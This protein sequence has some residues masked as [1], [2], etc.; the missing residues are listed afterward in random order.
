[1]DKS[2]FD[3]MKHVDKAVVE[4]EFEAALQNLALATCRYEGVRA[5]YLKFFKPKDADQSEVVESADTI[6]VKVSVDDE[7]FS[8]YVDSRAEKAAACAAAFSRNIIGKADLAM[9]TAWWSEYFRRQ[10]LLHPLDKYLD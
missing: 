8:A 2:N 9:R 7:R 10:E 4:K 3:L 5:V 6:K 1:M